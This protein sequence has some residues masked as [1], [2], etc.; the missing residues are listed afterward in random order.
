MCRYLGSSVAMVNCLGDDANGTAYLKRFEEVGIDTTHVH[1][2]AGVASGAA[3]IWVEASG[4]NRIIIVP[5]CARWARPH[6]L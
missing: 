4:Q 5:G 6:H 1:T 2:A 3:P